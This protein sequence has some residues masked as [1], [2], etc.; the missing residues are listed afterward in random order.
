MQEH[1][2]DIDQIVDFTLQEDGALALWTCAKN[3]I[4]G[5]GRNPRKRNAGFQRHKGLEYRECIRFFRCNK[6]LLF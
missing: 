6:T 4:A 2:S 3:V 5:D 1:Q